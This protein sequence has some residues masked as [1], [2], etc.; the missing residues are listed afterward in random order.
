MPQLLP[1]DEHMPFKKD[2]PPALHIVETEPFVDVEIPYEDNSVFTPFFT[3][4]LI[5]KSSITLKTER[6][7]FDALGRKWQLSN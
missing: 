3:G 2:G 7:F 5:V 6:G 1:L 4:G